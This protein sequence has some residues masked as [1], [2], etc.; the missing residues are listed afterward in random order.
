MHIRSEHLDQISDLV[1]RVHVL[2]VFSKE[3]LEIT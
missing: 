2:C 3:H 1:F